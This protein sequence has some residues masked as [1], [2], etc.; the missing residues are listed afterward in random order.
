[1]TDRE[2][3]GRAKGTLEMW[4]V[5]AGHLL[6]LL[7]RTTS[8]DAIDA[9]AVDAYCA[10]RLAE[11]GTKGRGVSRNTIGKE[12]GVL[13]VTLKL[14]ARRDEYP[15][16]VARVLPTGWG[17]DYKPCTRS[18][19]PEEARRLL[20]DLL[21]DDLPMIRSKAGPKPKPK[22]K[23]HAWTSVRELQ[24]TDGSR[25]D[26]ASGG[27]PGLHG[28]GAERQA[29]RPDG[30][31]HRASA[32]G[33]GEGRRARRED[34]LRGPVRLDGGRREGPSDRGGGVLRRGLPEALSHY[35][36]TRQRSMKNRAA[37][38]AFC[39]A[40]SARWS[41]AERARREDVLLINDAPA[42]VMLRGTKTE[43]ALRTVPVLP[44]TAPLVA[45]ALEH[46]REAGELFEAWQNVRR[47]LHA[48]CRRLG[49]A[50]VSPNDLRRTTGQWLRDAG[51][52]TDFIY[53]VLGHKD[54]RMVQRIYTKITPEALG[55]A[56]RA[57][58]GGVVPLL[59]K[60]K[61]KRKRKTG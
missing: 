4:A 15:H 38:V 19:T 41:E 61:P 25:G 5:K 16:D 34:A 59:P 23:D 11:P 33:A 39:I 6:R 44:T 55:E 35:D 31:G 49:I 60:A 14:A 26:R 54:S 18:L 56:L 40:T 10:A 57:R 43:G 27:D 13:G 3:R 52:E 7:G 22:E 51:V 9:R 30:D 24:R 45:L 21:D 47:D 37:C 42:Y 2:Q 12:L 36:R 48:A 1:M 46:G 8:L 28:G 29:E 32:E 20:A 17:S 50:P 53:P 58:V